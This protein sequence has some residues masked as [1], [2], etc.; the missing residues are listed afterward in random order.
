MR[1]DKRWN[2]DLDRLPMLTGIMFLKSP[3]DLEIQ[4]EDEAKLAGKPLK[5][6]F[7]MNEYSNF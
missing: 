3:D 7:K 6:K 2:G 5:T 4:R 1:K